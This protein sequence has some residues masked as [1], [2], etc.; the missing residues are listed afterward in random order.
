M[1]Q[2][3]LFKVALK[4]RKRISR[5][6]AIRG[7]QT[8]ATFHKVIFKAFAQDE[9]HLYTFYFSDRPTS[10]SSSRL[11]GARS[12]GCPY[13]ETDFQAECTRIDSLGLKLKDKFEYLSDYGNELWHEIT[14]QAIQAPQN[15]ISYPSIIESRGEF[16]IPY[17]DGE[18]F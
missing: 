12:Y 3:Y 2:I 17:E 16:P 11:R 5:L 8:L 13:S 14:L 7:D 6:I 10:T 4:Q 15:D 1:N 18:E 9:Q